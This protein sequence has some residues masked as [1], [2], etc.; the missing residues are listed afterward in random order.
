VTAEQLDDFEREFM[1]QH[2]AQLPVKANEVWLI[3]N[4]SGRW[5]TRQAFKLAAHH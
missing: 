2:R 1:H 3:E 4:I 5:E